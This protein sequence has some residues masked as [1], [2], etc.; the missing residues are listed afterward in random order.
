MNAEPTDTPLAVRLVSESVVERILKKA[1][2]PGAELRS[3]D[4]LPMK[5]KIALTSRVYKLVLDYDRDGECRRQSFILKT[6]SND[7][8]DVFNYLNFYEREIYAYNEVLP[9]QRM[10]PYPVC[11]YSD[12]D[13]ETGDFV[14]VLEDLSD[15]AVGDQFKGCSADAAASVL[16]KLAGFHRHGFVSIEDYRPS[17]KGWSAEQLSFSRKEFGRY[18][19]NAWQLFE[20]AMPRSFAGK[21]DAMNRSYIDVWLEIERG[22]QSLLHFDLRLDNL[23]F[24]ARNELAA[25]IDWQLARTGNAA[26]DVSL[27]LV[28]NAEPGLN[29]ADCDRLLRHYYTAAG[30]QRTSYRYEHFFADFRKS[31]LCHFYRELNY[32]GSDDYDLELRIRYADQIFTRYA[33]A[34]ERLDAVEFLETSV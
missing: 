6:Q 7:G 21:F 25:V 23:V 1:A 18:W 31:L 13:K 5:T 10:L 24:D 15:F 8:K 12:Y 34:L 32:L 33:A 14:I 11:Y 20:G 29:D 17:L 4:L 27:F 26:Y 28:G 2:R 19:R 3:Y 22:P 16:E 30:L 9:L